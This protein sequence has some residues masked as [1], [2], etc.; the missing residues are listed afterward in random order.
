MECPLNSTVP[1]LNARIERRAREGAAGSEKERRK[2][3]ES[4]PAG[5]GPAFG[6]LGYTIHSP[7]DFVGRKGMPSLRA[8][9]HQKAIA[10]TRSVKSKPATTA[11]FHEDFSCMY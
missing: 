7:P 10:I 5:W 9:S 3:A 6:G 1:C 4:G 2:M 11:R 8:Q